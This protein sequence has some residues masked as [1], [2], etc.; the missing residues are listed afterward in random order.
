MLDRGKKG[1]NCSKKNNYKKQLFHEQISILNQRKEEM[2]WNT[3]CQVE[4]IL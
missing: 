4:I 3:S 2:K 1:Q